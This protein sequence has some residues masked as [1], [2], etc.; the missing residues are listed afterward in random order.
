VSAPF[1]TDVTFGTGAAIGRYF[2]VVSTVPSFVLALW[3]YVL[4]ASGAATGSPSWT[5]LK[6]NNPFDNVGSAIAVVLLGIGLALVVHPTQFAIVQI[7]EGYGGTTRLGR[8]LRAR[9]VLGHLRRQAK[10]TQLVRDAVGSERRAIRDSGL[11]DVSSLLSPTRLSSRQ[12]DVLPVLSAQIQRRTASSERDSYPRIAADTLPTRLGNVLRRYEQ[13]AGRA[14]DLPIL[15]WATHIGMVADPAHT[16]YVGDRRTQLDLAVRMSAVSVVAAVFTFSLVWSDGPWALLTLVPYTAAW[17]SYRGAI[18]SAEGYGRALGAW[19]DLN[20]FR[21]YE[22]LH[23][24][25]VPSADRERVVNSSMEQ[26]RRGDRSFTFVYD[27]EP[28]EQGT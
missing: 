2:S 1:G 16:A 3:V 13:T 25:P 8:E 19:V 10:A 5:H 11:E 12:D 18:T 6:A 4:L 14:I 17:A 26:L 20:R 21:L 15:R 27:P 23:V 24:A 7:M 9:M 22:H 28:D